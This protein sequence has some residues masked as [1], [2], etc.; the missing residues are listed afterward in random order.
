MITIGHFNF[1][2]DQKYF[3]SDSNYKMTNYFFWQLKELNPKLIFIRKQK[4]FTRN[5]YLNE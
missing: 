3:S 1:F 4:L 5:N 2:D